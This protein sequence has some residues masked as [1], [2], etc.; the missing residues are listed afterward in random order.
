MIAPDLCPIRLF[1]S[2]YKG[3][4]ELTVGKQVRTLFCRPLSIGFSHR[5]VQSGSNCTG[6]GHPLVDD[7]R[8]SDRQYRKLLCRTEAQYPVRA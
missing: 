8:I 7:G 1:T 2:R 5:Y 3:D 6:L 4:A